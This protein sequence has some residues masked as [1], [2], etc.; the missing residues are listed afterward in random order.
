MDFLVSRSLRYNCGGLG[1][2]PLGNK[3]SVRHGID[4]SLT[5]SAPRVQPAFGDLLAAE[6]QFVREHQEPI[7]PD[8]ALRYQPQPWNDRAYY[9][10]L[11]QQR[12]REA[13]ALIGR[14]PRPRKYHVSDPPPGYQLR[15]RFGEIVSDLLKVLEFQWY[16]VAGYSPSDLV[17]VSGGDVG[18]AG[19]WTLPRGTER[20]FPRPNVTAGTKPINPPYRNTLVADLAQHLTHSQ[21]EV[22]ELSVGYGRSQPE[23]AFALGITTDAVVQRFRTARG[24][25]AWWQKEHLCP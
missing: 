4:C 14:A 24:R 7:D 18:R 19:G 1:H 9:R 3:L 5:D 10:A 11:K 22:Y 21:W 2:A 6:W 8:S 16:E 25:L 15:G 20:P 12:L 23:I 17:Y 13:P